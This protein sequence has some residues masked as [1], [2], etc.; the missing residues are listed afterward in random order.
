M[1]CAAQHLPR[2]A[3][4]GALAPV[5]PAVTG[6]AGPQRGPPASA[7]VCRL[8]GAFWAAP[9]LGAGAGFSPSPDSSRGEARAP[10]PSPRKRGWARGVCSIAATERAGGWGGGSGSFPLPQAGLGRGAGGSPWPPDPT[11][12]WVPGLGRARLRG[13]R[14]SPRPAL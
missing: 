1:G 9:H 3:A 5:P 7:E 6:P 10:N 11:A 13:S 2:Q 14:T 12:V 8:S 4:P